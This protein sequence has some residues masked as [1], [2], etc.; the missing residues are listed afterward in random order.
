MNLP[1]I[2]SLVCAGFTAMAGQIVFLRELL[3]V[4]YGNE[5][6]IGI[7]LACWLVAGG[8]GAL[9]FTALSGK[10]R[11]SGAF[12]YLQIAAGICLPLGILGCGYIRAWTGNAPGEIPPVPSITI[13]SFL[14]VLPLCAALGF[15]FGLAYRLYRERVR[16]ADIAAVYALEGAGSLLGGLTV[17][18]ILL[19]FFSG[20]E[21]ACLLGA[22]SCAAAAV[23]L[24]ATPPRS[25]CRLPAFI[26]A[27]LIVTVASGAGKKI[28][29]A[30]IAARWPGY[31]VAFQASSPYAATTVLRRGEQVSFLSN[32]LLVASVPDPAAA[33][34]SAHFALLEHPRPGKV[35]LI[36]GIP[37][38]IPG[39]IL[40]YP[41]TSV[42]CIELDSVLIRACRKFLPP[43]L[44]RDLDD[45]RVA[46][47][48]G[49]GRSFV[50]TS[51]RRYDCV[52]VAAGE[53][54]T[55]MANRYYTREFFREVKRVMNPGAIIAFD[56]PAS[57]SYLNT[58]RTR[59]LGCVYATLQSS[60][61]KIMVVPGE[62]A[63]FLATDSAAG[64]T[65]DYRVLM[66]RARE[67][68]ITMEYV[69]EY[70]LAS[71]MSPE[72]MA[73]MKN[74]LE[75]GAEVKENRDL[76]PAAYYY[77]LISWYTRFR[78][79]ILTRAMPAA[80]RY[81]IPLLASVAAA[82]LAMRIFRPRKGAELR[83][84]AVTGFSSSALQIML[85]FAFQVFYGYLFF[86]LGMLFTFFMA[87][88][89]LGAWAM[90][91]TART[92][93]ELIPLP[94]LFAFSAIFFA[95]LPLL[96]TRI[97]FIA[98]S[99]FSGTV[100]GAQ[101]AVAARGYARHRAPDTAAGTAYAVDL[102]GACLGAVLTGVFLVPVIGIPGCCVFL[103]VV[104]AI[105]AIP[106][107]S[108]LAKPQ[109]PDIIKP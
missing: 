16:G 104:N 86:E 70:Y 105:H 23:F 45:P 69:R 32:G 17:S 35:L 31:A 4:F 19:R 30:A 7:I 14:A 46:V 76:L 101:F 63:H 82:L 44:R 97:P 108:S 21:T 87:G 58:A 29:T 38:G 10:Y 71:S 75:G 64:F 13:L 92:G 24:A 96:F 74:T 106:G 88:L 37:R 91:R 36:G 84:L 78:G 59:A 49:D 60:F 80:E 18:F 11:M 61:S 1:L 109:P 55:A 103:A 67:R 79:S 3:T 77:G 48:E 94:L 72:R 53:P 6:S 8:A 25:R 54:L 9:A 40:K 83:A 81:L 52:L 98:L 12:P 62:T 50:K 65:P 73:W 41:G 22:L 57:E 89:S 34:G 43:A 51:V 15:M 47:I 107:K 102:A 5:L 27:A 56:L 95:F 100:T 42:D 68:G 26:A 93:K 33:E 20:L 39:E 99:F 2:V 85:V 90:R 66:R 28:D